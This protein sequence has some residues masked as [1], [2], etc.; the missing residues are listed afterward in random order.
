MKTL[1]LLSP[2]ASKWPSG[3]NVIFEPVSAGSDHVVA[4]D[5]LDAFQ[6][7]TTVLTFVEF[8]LVADSPRDASV[9]LGLKATLAA[10][11]ESG[12]FK[13]R[14]SRCWSTWAKRLR[15]WTVDER[16]LA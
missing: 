16:S 10:P 8:R 13:T 14:R 15:A 7:L 2:N 1:P 4:G 11:A 12:S 9:P 6:R 3:L 5:S